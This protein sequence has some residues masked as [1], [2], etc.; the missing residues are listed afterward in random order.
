MKIFILWLHHGLK[1]G[2]LHILIFGNPQKKIAWHTLNITTVS[3]TLAFMSWFL[4]S[5]VVVRLPQIGFSFSK[6]QLFWFAA[7]PGLAGGI[8]RIIHMFL[9]PIY[10]TKKVISIATLIKII[11]LLMLIYEINEPTTSFAFFIIIALLLGMGG[12]D[13]S[14]F[15]PSISTFFPKRLQGTALGI[16]TGVGNFGVSIIQFLFPWLM[17]IAIFGGLGSLQI[18]K[19]SNKH[20]W[21]Q[22]VM[23]L[24]IFLLVIVG[25]WA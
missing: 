15:M 20:V 19:S 14:S 8:L 1:N 22:N 25:I 6:T 21:M 18:I 16:Q 23:Y 17:W 13:F 10:G 4:I 2:N 11:P 7:M 12:G 24:I 3:L 9:I 5:V